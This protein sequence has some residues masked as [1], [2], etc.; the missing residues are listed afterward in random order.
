MH[1]IQTLAP[2]IYWV[3]G[4][5]R[6]LERFEN[7]FPLPGGVSYN[8]YLILDEKTVVMDTVDASISALY[9]ENIT[10]TL[11]GRGLDYLVVNHMEPDHCAAIDELLRRY[12]EMKI[13]G[14]RK[15]F[16]LIEQFY[17]FDCRKNYYEVK[18]GDEL[19][20][21]RHTLKFYF[22]PM[23]HWPEVMFAYE[24]TEKIL[25]SA[26]AFGSFIA[27]SGN[28]F[29]DQTDF[30]A[31]YL[32]EYRRYYANIV[33]KYGA[34]VQSALKKLAGTDIQMICPLH[35]PIWRRDLS[36][37]LDLYD[38]WS[39]Y[40]PEKKGVLLVYASMYGNTENVVNRVAHRLSQLGITDMRMYDVSKTHASFIIAD[41]W[42][43]SHIVLASPTYNMGLY[44]GME[45]LLREMAGLLLQNRKVSIIGNYSWACASVRVMKELVSGMK[46]M[47]LVGEPFE[48]RS[49]MKPAQEPE[50]EALTQEIFSSLSSC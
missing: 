4:S 17:D 29:I 8:S 46:N 33:G 40:E 19:D 43:Y 7:M 20:T 41:A 23:V 48:I 35:G 18:E 10:H 14:N 39:R 1:C 22:A 34:Q 31:L 49:S 37:I 25:F 15:T 45:N 24:K 9:L 50:L 44:Y 36:V 28:L 26:D 42:K 47:E 6:R 13:V 16:Q 11:S 30:E 21:G 3:G 38:R 2:D 5:D 27:S 32:D 12:P